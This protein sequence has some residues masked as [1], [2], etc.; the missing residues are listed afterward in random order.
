MQRSPLFAKLQAANA[1]FMSHQGWEIPASFG[2]ASGSAGSPSDLVEAE[3]RALKEGAG[4]LDLSPRGLI[5]A[6]GKDAPR[7]LH[8]ML[9]NEVKGLEMGR[10]NYAFLLDVHGHILADLQILRTGD[11]S[12]L[13]ICDPQLTEVILKTL[14]RYIIADVVKLEYQS[15]QTACL[16]LEGPCAREVLREAVGFDPP[17]MHALEHLYLEDLQA[18]LIRASFAGEEGFWILCT[19]DQATKVWQKSLE[20]G[21]ALGLKPAGWEALEIR[22]I[23][24]GILRYGADITEKNLPQETGQMQAFSFSKGCYIG[25]EVVERIRSRGHVNR[26]LAGLL[27]EGEQKVPPGT[28]ILAG[29]K[30]VGAVTSSVYSLGLRRN[31][32]LGYL[33]REHAEAGKQVMAG[34]VPA[35]VANLPFSI[36]S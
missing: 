14:R 10:G 1:R 35:K 31:I 25:Q 27:L 36:L 12:F 15:A 29:D 9:S 34:T 5:L 32:A 13:L 19:P 11:T 6:S 18:R 16:G 8:G 20:A 21:P 2:S 4:L 28:E 30:P 22:R 7:F 26:M 33:R 3:Y 24:A 23:E 17:H